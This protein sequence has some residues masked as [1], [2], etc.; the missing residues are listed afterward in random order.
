MTQINNQITYADSLGRNLQE[1]DTALLTHFQG[2]VGG[3]HILP[4]YPSSADR[5]F[6]PPVL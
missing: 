6:A 2:A 3:I 4:F 1:L 5:G